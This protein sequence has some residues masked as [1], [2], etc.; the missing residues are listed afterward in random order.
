MDIKKIKRI[1]DVIYV[2]TIVYAVVI[3]GKNYYDRSILPEGVCPVNNNYIYIISAI[4]LLVITFI[5]TSIIDH[6]YKKDKE[7]KQNQE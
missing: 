3:V 1:S 6:K 7:N 4:G 5:T 2:I